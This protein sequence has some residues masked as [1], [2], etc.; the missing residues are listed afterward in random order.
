MTNKKHLDRNGLLTPRHF[1]LRI[2]PLYRHGCL[3]APQFDKTNSDLKF[4]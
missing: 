2:T 4:W 1:R 3:V